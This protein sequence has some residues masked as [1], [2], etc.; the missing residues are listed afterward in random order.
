MD[1][2]SSYIINGERS[3]EIF[4]EFEN[5]DSVNIL[6]KLKLITYKDK[7]KIETIFDYKAI[8]VNKTVLDKEFELQ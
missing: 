1:I 2:Y 8:D 4:K 7:I 6:K 3:V 5:H